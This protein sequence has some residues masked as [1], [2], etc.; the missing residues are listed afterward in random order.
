MDDERAVSTGAGGGTA[1]AG[2]AG[3]GAVGDGAGGAGAAV[4]GDER[5]IAALTRL[6]RDFSTER[7]WVRFHDPKSL[8][9][10]LVGE[11]GELAELFQ[12]APADE[13]VARFA[14]PDR[15]A[16]AA[17]ELADVVVYLLRLA[18]VLGIDLG[19]AVRAKMAVNGHRFV[20]DEVRGKAPDKP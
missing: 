18:D 8:L 16:R 17:E 10:A 2:A 3:A 13:A 19:E 12:W 5:E 14:A 20:A 15:K 11:V 9:L 7:E 4:G 6:V 1:G